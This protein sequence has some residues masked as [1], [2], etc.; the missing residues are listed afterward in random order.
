MERTQG[1]DYV[2]AKQEHVVGTDIRAEYQCTF[3]ANVMHNNT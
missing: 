2:S 1:F 3:D